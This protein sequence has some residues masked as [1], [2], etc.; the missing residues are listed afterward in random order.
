MV[1]DGFR[2][3]VLK[4]LTAERVRVRVNGYELSF[5]VGGDRDPSSSATRPMPVS[6]LCPQFDFM[7]T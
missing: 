1:H 6:P 5:R 2:V 4:V 3:N 7:N